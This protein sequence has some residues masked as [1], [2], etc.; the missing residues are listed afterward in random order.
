MNI[1]AYSCNKRVLNML[2]RLILSFT[3]LLSG[4]AALPSVTRPTAWASDTLTIK[5]IG[6]SS[7]LPPHP[8]ILQLEVSTILGNEYLTLQ[9]FESGQFVLQTADGRYL[10]YPGPTSYL[11]VKVDDIV[12][13]N[14]PDL[15]HVLSVDM[16][17]QF[18]DMD[19]DGIEDAAFITYS[20]PEKVRVNQRL[21][22][23]G[24]ALKITVDITNQDVS[25]HTVSIRHLIDTQVDDNDGSPLWMAGNVYVAEVELAPPFTTWKGYDRLPDPV[26]QSVGTLVTRPD[27]M[28][29]A[30]WPVAVDSP[31]EYTPDPRRQFYTPGFVTSPE[32]DSCVLMY[33]NLGELASTDGASVETYYGVGAPAPQSELK[34]LLLAL[35]KVHAAVQGKLDSDVS[36]LAQV[37][38]SAYRAVHGKEEPENFIIGAFRWASRIPLGW[39]RIASKLFGVAIKKLVIELF[40]K[41]DET[42]TERLDRLV[43]RI[44]REANFDPDDPNLESKIEHLLLT[45]EEGPYIQIHK[46]TLSERFAA[47]RTRIEAEYGDKGL[48][49]TF[50]LDEVLLA[51]QQYETSLSKAGSFEV[52]LMWINPEVKCSEFAKAGKMSSWLQ[53]IQGLAPLEQAGAK[54][55]TVG[56]LVG[57]GMVAGKGVWAF[58]SGGMSLIAELAVAQFAMGAG[59]FMGDAAAEAVDICSDATHGLAAVQSMAALPEEVTTLEESFDKTLRYVEAALEEPE[60]WKGFDGEIMDLDFPDIILP[61]GSNVGSTEGRVR[62]K[63]TG[64]IPANVSVFVDIYAPPRAGRRVISVTQPD[65][66]SLMPG[67][68]RDIALRYGAPD[69]KVWEAVGSYQ[70]VVRVSIGTKLRS[71]LEYPHLSDKTVFVVG[72]EEAVAMGNMQLVSTVQAGHISEGQALRATHTPE[73]SMQRTEFTLFQQGSD[74]D[75]HLYDEMGNHVGLNYD[76][77]EVEIGIPGARY[78]GSTADPEWITVEQSGGRGYTT[79]VV[80]VEVEQATESYQVIAIDIPFYPAVLGVKPTLISLEVQERPEQPVQFLMMPMEYG[81][82]SNVVNLQ[83]VASDLVNEKGQTIP[84]SSLR[85]DLSG[86]TIPAGTSIPVTGTISIPP[87]TY[88]GTYTGT[89]RLVGTD[90]SQQ[91][92]VSAEARLL[93]PVSLPKLPGDGNGDGLCTEVDA[94]MA[95]QMAVGKLAED[96]NMDV[97]QDG[98]VTERDAL[99]ILL[100]AIRD[101]QCG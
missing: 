12:Y 28:V 15:P 8:P 18:L 76:T 10:L 96:L 81:G 4:T 47:F 91:T 85:F 61:S 73:E 84:A 43:F 58:C 55:K 72:S 64:E 42:V 3:L 30:H 48:P 13:A 65:I 83:T 44:Y 22:L 50:P 21:E 68:E 39:D 51:L 97:D 82:Q 62:V 46:Q 66:V 19:D 92:P 100:W 9:V 98:Q 17:L 53:M 49:P 37:Q 56:F 23:A 95:L 45:Y 70:V 88:A 59:L 94:L 75:L 71:S 89:I 78:S 24:E 54:F 1:Y 63:N 69:T 36:A 87:G 32:S 90:A 40:E 52:T 101:G 20:T 16:P 86:T 60:A 11:S 26:L 7:I 38:A 27:R 93:I 25:S 29:F 99:T 33:F 79:E 14:S 74:L 5:G 67:E 41:M 57:A 2:I 31:W 6:R 80:A 35:D 34:Q 77:G